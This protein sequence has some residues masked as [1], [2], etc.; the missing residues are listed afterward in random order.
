[1]IAD[2]YGEGRRM[3]DI[4]TRR[5]FYTPRWSPDSKR[6]AFGDADRALCGWR[7]PTAS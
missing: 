6:L 1:V 2:Q 7:W 5:F 4:P 3:I